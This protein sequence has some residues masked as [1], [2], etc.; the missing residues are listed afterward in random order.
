MEVGEDC[1]GD[2]RVG[3]GWLDS[4]AEERG[5]EESVSLP[6]WCPVRFMFVVCHIFGLHEMG[7]DR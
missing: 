1:R 5:E 6:G 2:E 4:E 3:D 7:E